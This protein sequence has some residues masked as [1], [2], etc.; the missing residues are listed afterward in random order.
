VFDHP[1]HAVLLDA[2][3]VLLLPDPAALR[4]ALAPLG[5]TPDDERCRLAHYAGTVEIDRLQRVD[6]L[7]ADRVIAGFLGVSEPR[8][9]DALPLIESVYVSDA[10]VP[11]PGVTDALLTLQRSGMPLAVVSNASGQMERQLLT[12]RIC[13]VD[14]AGAPTGDEFAEVA[15]V[16]DSDVVGV[17]K[18]DPRIFDI[19]LDQLDVNRENAVY[20]GDTVYF[21][22]LGARAAGISP[23]HVDPYGLCPFDDHPH[24]GSLADLVAH[25]VAA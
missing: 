12:H 23:V 10:W 21:D 17:E 15:I 22:V 19:A 4:R 16:V 13:A 14:P 25:L 20:V 11:V 24:V 3:G 9:E 18:P 2:G 1:V 5:A 7:A 6:W 8:I